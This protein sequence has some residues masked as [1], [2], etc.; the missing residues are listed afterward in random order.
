MAAWLSAGNSE[1]PSDSVLREKMLL[2]ISGLAEDILT[3]VTGFPAGVRP[4]YS[5]SSNSMYQGWRIYSTQIV[6]G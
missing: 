2:F 4:P 1:G 3:D 6:S 5:L